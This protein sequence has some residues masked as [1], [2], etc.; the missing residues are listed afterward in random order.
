MDQIYLVAKFRVH[1][2]ADFKSAAAEC[3]EASR[4]HE[5]GTLAYE[6]FMSEDE[7]QAAMI[8]AYRDSAALLAHMRNAAPRV[9]KLFESAEH[10]TQGL[11]SPS[12]ALLERL[13]GRIRFVPRHAGLA[14]PSLADCGSAAD[15]RSVAQ[16]RIKP[17]GMEEF[18]AGVAAGLEAVET[19]DPGTLAYEW[20]LNESSGHCT[21]LEMYRDPA[22]LT[23]HA[24]NVGHLVRGLLQSADL[25]AEI[26]GR[27]ASLAQLAK[28][29]M[30]KLGLFQGLGR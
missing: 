21:V 2:A 5:P 15:I 30:K 4:E 8:E 22:S 7:T 3:L 28:F 23:A 20:F 24:K 29:P 27:S 26:Y 19:L 16:F 25:D 17:D 11:G 18:K 1:R 13:A 10:T 6:W 14:S 12:P 9:P